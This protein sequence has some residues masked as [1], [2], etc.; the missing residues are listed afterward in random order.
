[1]YAPDVQKEQRKRPEQPAQP[2]QGA[3]QFKWVLCGC[4]RWASGYWRHCSG[5]SRAATVGDSQCDRCTRTPRVCHV[6]GN[7]V[8]RSLKRAS[9]DEPATHRQTLPTST[10]QDMGELK[11]LRGARDGV[12][13]PAVGR[14]SVAARLRVAG[15]RQS[16]DRPCP[17]TGNYRPGPDATFQILSTHNPRKTPALHTAVQAS[18]A[19]QHHNRCGDNTAAPHGTCNTPQRTPCISTRNVPHDW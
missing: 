3:T 15:R 13:S 11:S 12:P 19:N 10:C 17:G 16:P 9:T 2:T 6:S 18:H 1:M 8:G 7:C 4:T 5:T 14:R